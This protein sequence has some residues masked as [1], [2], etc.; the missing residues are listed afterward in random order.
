[1]L[2]AQSCPTLCDPMV[3]PWNF[4]GKNTAMGCHSLLQGSFPPQGLNLGLLHCR[5]IL[6]H[7]NYQGSPAHDKTSV[8]MRAQSSLSIRHVKTHSEKAAV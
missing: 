7:L 6:Y 3:C 2:V 5:Q 1:M 8:L 4:L